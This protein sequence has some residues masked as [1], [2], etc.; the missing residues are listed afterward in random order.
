MPKQRFQILFRR[1][2]QRINIYS[3]NLFRTPLFYLFDINAALFTKKKKGIFAGAT[4]R[5]AK[6]EPSRWLSLDMAGLSGKVIAL[7]E[8]EDLRQ[9]FDPTLIVEFYSR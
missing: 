3:N 2:G 1:S 6:Y 7:P 8:G 9:V 4:E 5:L